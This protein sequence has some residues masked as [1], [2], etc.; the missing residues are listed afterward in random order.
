MIYYAKI[1]DN[2]TKECE[3]G[4][5]D[6]FKNQG[7]PLLD[8]EMDY[9]GKW[10]LSGYAPK[11]PKEIYLEEELID[12]HQKLNDS[13]YI[14]NKLAEIVDDMNAYREMK[15]HY[16]TQLSQRAFWRKRIRE[17]EEELEE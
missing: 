7:Y 9:E 12:L 17:I 4:N 3:V 14:T 10:F 2:I 15:E 5:Q 16:S 1:I 6:D 13:D 11:K 8:V